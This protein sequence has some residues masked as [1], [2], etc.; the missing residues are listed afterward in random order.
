AVDRL[1]RG[2]VREVVAHPFHGGQTQLDASRLFLGGFSPRVGAARRSRLLLR[3]LPAARR[4]GRQEPS[5]PG[6]RAR[7]AC[8]ARPVPPG[9]SPMAGNGDQ[10]VDPT[11]SARRP[12]D[13]GGL[14]PRAAASAPPNRKPRLRRSGV[15]VSARAREPRVKNV[16]YLHGFASSPR[17]RKIAALRE[18]LEPDGLRIVAPDLNIPSFERLDF[19][20]MARL[21]FWEIK[22]HMPAVVVGSSLGAMVALEAARMGLKAPLVLIAP[23]LGFGGRWMEKLPEGD[24]IRI[25]HFGDE[26]ELPIHRRFF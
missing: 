2:P 22:R 4:R 23:A 18:R 17:G 20:A 12:E 1:F 11:L 10:R 26:R 6:A 5:P 19:R 3:E 21:S 13:P 9:C 15:V 14:R 7:A 16:L 25:F 8:C 24:P